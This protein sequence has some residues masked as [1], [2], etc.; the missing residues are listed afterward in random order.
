MPVL[1]PLGA[2]DPRYR[3]V[4]FIGA[5]AT[6]YVKI[7]CA[8]DPKHRLATLQIGSPYRLRLRGVLRTDDAPGLEREYHDRWDHLRH[9]GEWFKAD[10]DLRKFM[11]DCLFGIEEDAASLIVIARKPSAKPP[12]M[13]FY[14]QPNESAGDFTL[15]F[16]TVM[17][18]AEPDRYE[19]PALPRR[20]A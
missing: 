17:H 1:K 3:Y 19:A 4:Y 20:R 13:A 6:G 10:R 11:R 15:R 5:E 12:L 7:G 18:A 2:P 9:H 16:Q 8:D 14:R